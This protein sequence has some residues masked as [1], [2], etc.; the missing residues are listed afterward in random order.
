MPAGRAVVA[1]QGGS[2]I[3]CAPRTTEAACGGPVL[4]Q[5]SPAHD[6]VFVRLA[7][8]VYEAARTSRLRY[9]GVLVTGGVDEDAMQYWVRGGLLGMG[10]P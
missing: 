7:R 3:D 5:A 6:I 2:G 10:G 1:D 9:Q 4:L 8:T